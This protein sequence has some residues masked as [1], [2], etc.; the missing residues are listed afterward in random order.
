M[1]FEFDDNKPIYKQLVDK[2]K[3][4][5]ITGYYKSGDRLPSVRDLAME[6]SV[7]P[8]TIQR[9]LGELENEHLI[10]TKRTL[11][12]FVTDDLENIQKVR[13]EIG[14]MKVDNFISD[15]HLLEFERD[16]VI[17]LMKERKQ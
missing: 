16:E 4:A 13:L 5:I 14:T 3:I 2:L 8:N 11:G 17:Q 9:A 10:Y 7:N 12:K 1:D 6:I 15:M